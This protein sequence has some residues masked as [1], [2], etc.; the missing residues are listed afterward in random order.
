[1][2]ENAFFSRIVVMLLL[3][4]SITVHDRC[5]YCLMCVVVVVVVVGLKGIR[6]GNR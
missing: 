5:C 1:M 4:R 2:E 3:V 6:F